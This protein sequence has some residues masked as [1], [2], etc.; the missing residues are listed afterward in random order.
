[1]H[2]T[3][4]CAVLTATAL[5]VTPFARADLEV[6][7][8]VSG[9]IKEIQ[10]L[11]RFIEQQ[12]AGG[13]GNDP[14]KVSVHSI[15]GGTGEPA[16]PKTPPVKIHPPQFSSEKLIPGQSTLVTVAV[17][18]EEGEVDTLAIQIV[19]TNL[20]TDLYDD[21]SHGDTKP[22]DGVWSV[23]LT[24]MEATPAG[25]YDVIVTGFGPHGR[26]LTVETAAGEESP[27]EARTQVAVER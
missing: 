9:D 27:L 10:A 17:R 14:L 21:G 13:G 1:M 22:N 16:A 8:T 26:A 20:K 12:N 4:I 15:A 5:L 3:V 24:P 2:R 25:T 23:T 19:G 7:L 11:L 18:D 6:S